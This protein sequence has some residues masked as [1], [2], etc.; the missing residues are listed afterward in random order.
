MKY[1]TNGG[2]TWRLLGNAGMF[3]TDGKTFS[4]QLAGVC[5]SN[6]LLLRTLNGTTWE[7]VAGPSSRNLW[8]LSFGDEQTGWGMGSRGIQTVTTD[9]GLTWQIQ[10]DDNSADSLLMS[11]Q[12]FDGLTAR[13]T[14]Y[15]GRSYLTTDG[16]VT[17]N[18][19]ETGTKE[20]LLASSFLT[21]TLGWV[22]GE[23]GMVL[24]YGRLPYG[25][26]EEKGKPTMPLVTSLW[27]NRPN[28]FA[29]R[30]EVLYQLAN[31]GKV[32]LVVYNVLGQAVRRLVNREEEPG[33]YA[34]SWDGRDDAGRSVSSGVY[35]Y[36]LEALGRTQ[37]RKMVKV[38]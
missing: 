6:G 19:E 20:W 8:G 17:W 35:F 21:P 5:G 3:A 36:R 38:R 14:G 37:T 10:R 4:S 18:S 1:S 11:V 27:Q 23:N 12:G 15:Q 22:A 29:E 31:K 9:Q 7:K 2:Q 32:K 33:T 30:T 16:G 26:E 25:V 13:A 24:K 28:P 34:M